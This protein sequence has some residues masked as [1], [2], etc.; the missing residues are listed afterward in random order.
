ME[1][2]FKQMIQD[3][4]AIEAYINHVFMR[5]TMLIENRLWN[6]IDIFRYRS[7]WKNFSGTQERLLAAL[8]IDRLIYRS[9]E[10]MLSMLFDLLTISLPN[11]MRLQGDVNYQ[12][13]RRLLSLLRQSKEINIRLVNFNENDKPSQSS[14]EITNIINHYMKVKRKFIIT[15]NLIESKY[16]EGVRTFILVDDMICTGGQI[17]TALDAI[18]PEKYVDA[19]FYVAVCCACDEGLSYIHDCYPNIGI[20]YTEY[21]IVEDHS[22]FKSLDYSKI[23]FESI[24]QMK[25]FYEEFTIPKRFMKNKLYGKGDLALVYAFQNSTPNASLPILYWN[26][27]QFYQFLNKRGA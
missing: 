8:I 20:A 14:G 9:E 12:R 15:Q 5:G 6:G 4:D 19:K 3:Q 1:N 26:N 24:E 27:D 21:L 25:H 7:W 11:C 13:N 10:H 2:G 22:F 18:Q 16:Q 23:P 17:K